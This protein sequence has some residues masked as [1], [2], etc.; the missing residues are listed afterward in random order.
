[1]AVVQPDS[2][3]APDGVHRA[4]S[5]AAHDLNN[6]RFRL[7]LLTDSFRDH[8][9]DPKSRDEAREMLMDTARLVGD[10]IDRLRR[11]SRSGA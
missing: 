8:L 2:G 7:T 3:F 6:V 4:L 9:E 10:I 1:M 5:T 11:A